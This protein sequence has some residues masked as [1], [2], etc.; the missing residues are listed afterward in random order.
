MK[1]VA[2]MMGIIGLVIVLLLAGV[3]CS[4]AVLPPEGYLKVTSSPSGATIGL[5]GPEGPFVG[6][7]W[8]TPYAFTNL[9]PGTYTIHLHL[10]GYQDWSTTVQLMANS[11]PQ[12][13]D[14]TL[15]PI[16]TPT[17][18]ATGSISISSSP[19][20]AYIYLD[21][22]PKGYAPLTIHDVSPGTHAI[23]ATLAGYEDWATNVEVTSGSTASV[24]A[25]LTRTS[26]PTPTP[27]VPTTVLSVIVALAISSIIAAAKVRRGGKYQKR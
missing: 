27:K 17:P 4:T 8:E 6:P 26:T 19:S 16:P 11:P 3:A 1:K 23:K 7:V 2:N 12:S 20:G 24:S 10:D 21:G 22:T 14:A 5:E 15:A 18:P 13:I 25:S 9:K